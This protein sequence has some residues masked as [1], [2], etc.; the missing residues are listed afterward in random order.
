MNTPDKP[1]STQ[2]QPTNTHRGCIR[3]SRPTT[4]LSCAVRKPERKKSPPSLIN[5]GKIEAVRTDHRKKIGFVQSK[6]CNLTASGESLTTSRIPTRTVPILSRF[7]D[8]TIA[9]SFDLGEG[10]P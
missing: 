7:R 6:N 9:D 5:S 8:P 3:T 10:A 4:A 1:W 2:L